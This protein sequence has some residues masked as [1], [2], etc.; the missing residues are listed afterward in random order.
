M[1]IR[2]FF[3]VIKKS[4]CFVVFINLNVFERPLLF[5]CFMLLVIPGRFLYVKSPTDFNSVTYSHPWL[6]KQIIMNHF[7]IELCNFSI[8]YVYF[9]A[10]YPEMPAGT[11][12]FGSNVRHQIRTI[13]DKIQNKK[14]KSTKKLRK[15]YIIQSK[16]QNLA[17][18]KIW[19]LKLNSDIF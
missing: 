1:N 3:V 5:D 12:S 8:T 17:R 6:I 16:S 9:K 11:G 4:I 15:F 7:G 10:F 13:V 19:N 2:G 18:S 14:R